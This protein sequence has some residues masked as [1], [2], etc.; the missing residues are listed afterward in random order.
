MHV[1]ITGGIGSGKTT[2][3]KI[4]ESLNIP[5]Y[6]ADDRAKQLMIEDRK[7]VEAIETTFGAE[8]YHEN[9][10]LNR[11]YLSGIVFKDPVK[12]RQLN[13]LV[14]PVVFQDGL[15]WQEE[16]KDALYTLK[17]AA[18]LYESGSFRALDRMIC[19]YAPKQIRLERV[20]QRDDASKK[21]VLARMN[22]QLPELDKMTLSDFVITND[23]Q[24]SLISQVL[25]IH[26]KLTQ[27]A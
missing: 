22:K 23:G 4:F 12:L 27:N 21:A 24:S 16:H 18:L 20:M 11:A 13:Q 26:R 6:Y 1:G 17:E 5:V 2:V 19:V 25:T 9:G 8:S 3:C 10:Q 7:L 14:H 15:K